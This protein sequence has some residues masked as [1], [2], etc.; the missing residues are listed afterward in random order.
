[1]T[2]CLVRKRLMVYL[3]L[4]LLVLSLALSGCS[5]APAGPEGGKTGG[6]AAKTV[7]IGIVYP[8][9]GVA[10]NVGL[11]CKY[12]IELAVEIINGKYDFNMPLAKEEGLPGLGGAKIE[13]V[14][15]DHQGLPEK[16]QSEVERLVT[17]EGVVAIQG[18]YLSSVTQTASQAA[19]RLGIPMINGSSSS[20]ALTER[21]LKWFFRTSPHDGHIVANLFDL[22]DDVRSKKGQEIK[23]IGMIHENTLQGADMGNMVK[24][25]AD[26][27][28]YEVVEQLPFPPGTNDVTSEVQKLKAS[29]PDVIIMQAQTP[30][31]VL[32]MKTMKQ[33]DYNPDA[34]LGYGAGFVD[35]KFFEVFGKNAEGVI[36][37]AAW[38][39][40]IAEKKGDAKAIADMFREKYKQEMTENSARNF[41]AF[42]TLADAI[43]RA[44][45]TD[46]EAIRKALTETD[47][48]GDQLIMPWE[49]VKFGADG[50]N[51]YA[52][53]V[54]TQVFDGKHYTVW[55]FDLASREVVWPRPKWSELE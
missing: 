33:F 30:D 10:A 5:S 26:E 9:S 23:T 15:A 44:G 53:G 35:P 38:A 29:D 11:D 14:V 49:G 43:N 18:C 4:M 41:T 40:D 3:T 47:I 36:T 34:I 8:L 2:T 13:L 28:G 48:P 39:L 31:A 55:P 37:K 19:E 50:Q 54:C 25:L 24:K 51:I 17:Q 20:I 21:G 16:G 7:K 42:I 22:M 27:R 32:F 52:S 12:G 45:S 6:T 1:M 46:P